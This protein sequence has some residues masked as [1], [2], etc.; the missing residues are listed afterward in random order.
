MG[1]GI[2]PRADFPSLLLRRPR[3]VLLGLSLRHIWRAGL[4]RMLSDGL[5]PQQKVAADI[6]ASAFGAMVALHGGAIAGGHLGGA[7]RSDDH[8]RCGRRLSDRRDLFPPVSADLLHEFRLQSGPIAA[9]GA[10]RNAADAQSSRSCAVCAGQLGA[11]CG[12]GAD[13]SAHGVHFG[14][15]CAGLAVGLR[16]DGEAARKAS[17]REAGTADKLYFSGGLGCRFL[18]A[19]VEES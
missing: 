14:E 11:I 7:L 8:D 16:A 17:F 13:G 1:A 18:P 15:H 6:P 12:A 19:A 3:H 10:D 2:W 4:R 5:R 9:G